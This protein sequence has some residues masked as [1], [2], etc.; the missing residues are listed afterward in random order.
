MNFSGREFQFPSLK[1]AAV[2]IFLSCLQWGVMALI[3][4]SFVYYFRIDITYGQ[5][6]FTYL[7]ASMVGLITHIPAGLGVVEAI[8]LK[9]RLNV[10]SEDLVIALICFR[11]VYYLIPLLIALPSY[12]YLE[13]F[14]KR[15]S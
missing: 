12:L 11:I 8:F 10:N 6:L 9:L 2:Q 7:M 4:Y 14:Q 15:R 13:Y 3:I 5:V 1:L